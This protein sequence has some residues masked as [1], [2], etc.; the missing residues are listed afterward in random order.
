MTRK[1]ET[2][3]WNQLL[4]QLLKG[5]EINQIEKIEKEFEKEMKS[6]PDIEK[7][8]LKSIFG[9]N[10]INSEEAYKDVKATYKFG[11]DSLLSFAGVDVEED[12]V[13][14]INEYLESL[15]DD[16]EKKEKQRK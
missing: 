16:Y 6:V 15:I 4:S 9:Y 14:M 3:S 11:V 12:I 10:K 8:I 2:L 5:K 13:K 1:K 7:V